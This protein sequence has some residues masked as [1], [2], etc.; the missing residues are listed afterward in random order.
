MIR[1]C[2]PFFI[3]THVCH[4]CCYQ[5]AGGYLIP[6]YTPFKLTRMDKD[7]SV[8]EKRMGRCYVIF[9]RADLLF[10]LFKNKFVGYDDNCSC[11]FY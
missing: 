1:K 8:Q 5:R 4:V 2:Y 7:I 10:E 11:I 3:P 9:N 6:D